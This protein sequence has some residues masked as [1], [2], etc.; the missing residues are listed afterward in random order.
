VTSRKWCYAA[1]ERR[2]QN[3]LLQSQ[4]ILQGESKPKTPAQVEATAQLKPVMN[5][6]QFVTMMTNRMG[7]LEANMNREASEMRSTI[8][9]IVPKILSKLEEW[10]Q[11]TP[12]RG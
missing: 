11:S 6:P 8:N 12:S 4:K 5:Y 1:K 10:L 7:V 9:E 2:Q 3:L